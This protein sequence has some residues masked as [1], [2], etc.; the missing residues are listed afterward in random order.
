VLL[1]GLGDLVRPGGVWPTG[2]VGTGVAEAVGLLVGEVLA[3][4]VGVTD[5]DGGAGELIWPGCGTAAGGL[6]V[7]CPPCRPPSGWPGA[8]AAG[9]LG[10]TH[11]VNG[12]CG[13]PAIATTTA[14]RQMARAAATLSPAPRRIRRRRPDG[15]ANTGAESTGGV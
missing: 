15:S 11:C 12:A 1:C 14:P 7:V 9:E 3:V 6:L 2:L 13:P 10:A 8:A 4:A 5:G